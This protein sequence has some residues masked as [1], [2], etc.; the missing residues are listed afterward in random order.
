[1]ERI[2][3]KEH[4]ILPPEIMRTVNECVGLMKSLHCYSGTA[5]MSFLKNNKN[6]N[7]AW[8]LSIHLATVLKV[9]YTFTKLKMDTIDPYILIRRRGNGSNIS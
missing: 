5:D 6:K 1:M 3:P 8:T 9:C 2:S 4:F 7:V